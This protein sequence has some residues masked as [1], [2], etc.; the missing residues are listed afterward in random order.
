MDPFDSSQEEFDE[1]F[2][3]PAPSDQELL[4]LLSQARES[5]NVPLRR[6]VYCYRTLRRVTS[7]LVNGIEERDG[8]AAAQS[9]PLFGLAKFLVRR[10]RDKSGPS[11]QAV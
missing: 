1:D 3:A 11:E 9:L 7:D 6:L 2:G 10:E 5:G 4:V 8:P